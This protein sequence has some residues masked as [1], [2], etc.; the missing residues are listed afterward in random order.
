M[1]Y[2]KFLKEGGTIG[3]VAPSFG[4]NIEPYKSS[5]D[6]AQKVLVKKGGY[7]LD[8]GPNA[9]AGEGI[10]IS[11]SPDKCAAEFMEYYLKEDVD[12]LMSCGGGELMC[13]ILPW[14]D[15]EQLKNAPAK[16]LMGYSDNTNLIFLLT[17]IC[18]TAG[19]Y[20]PCAPSFGT[21]PWHISLQDAYDVLTGSKTT[22][23]N[24]EKWEK[25]S[26]RDEDHP[27]LPYNTTEDFAMHIYDGGEKDDCE[28]NFSGRLVGGCLDIL[29]GLCGT[30]YDKVKEFNERYKDDGIIWFI[31]S[32]D[33][34]PMDM[35]RTLFS[36]R[37]AGWFEKAKGFLIG[38]PLHFGEEMLGVDQYNA[39]T[40]ILGGLGVP[41]IMDLD[42]G[43]LPPM[44]PIVSGSMGNVTVKDGSLKLEMEYI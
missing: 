19:I 17:T 1:R 15:F 41:I 27:L 12:V 35:R 34:G 40:D 2:G 28:L 25:E 13:E 22:V 24:Y 43:H 32:C 8:L 38:R 6:N 16:W 37:E 44:M 30:R 18:D 36:L 14:L 42:I 39:V 9:Y 10:G 5:F 29:K 7:R 31:E 20:A 11:N 3:F 26:L 33:L 23:S 4:C 21:E